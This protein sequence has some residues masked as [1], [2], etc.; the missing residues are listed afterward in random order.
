[1]AERYKYFLPKSMHEATSY[2]QARRP[3]REHRADVLRQLVLVQRPVLN[4]AISGVDEAL[5]DMKERQA[6]MPVY[7]LEGG[8]KCRETA[9]TCANAGGADPKDAW[10]RAC[11]TRGGRAAGFGA[12]RNRVRSGRRSSALSA[13]PASACGFRSGR[14]RFL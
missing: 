11:E 10:S 9:Q 5:W 13:R 6:G 2:R 3:H 1:M 8:G 4:N 12:M 14:R 7:D